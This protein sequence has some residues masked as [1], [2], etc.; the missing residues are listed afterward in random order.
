[1]QNKL[2]LERSEEF[3][4]EFHLKKDDYKQCVFKDLEELLGEKNAKYIVIS[5]LYSSFVTQSYEYRLGIYGKDLYLSNLDK[6]IYRELPL[7]KKYITEDFATIDKYILNYMQ[8]EE[9]T[10]CQKRD[11][12]CQYSLRY[13]MIGR[14]IWRELID[15]F[16]E[17]IN[18]KNRAVLDNISIVYGLYMERGE[19]FFSG[20][21]V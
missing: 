5:P 18:K 7:M 4:K 10:D 13:L 16:V 17:Y 21:I 9:V 12:K 2:F 6:S 14:Q 20:D 1:M 8:V 19:H 3:L 15:N 11:M